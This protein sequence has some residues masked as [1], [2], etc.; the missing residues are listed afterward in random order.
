MFYAYSLVVIGGIIGI[1]AIAFFVF[2]CINKNKKVERM[3]NFILF[4]PKYGIYC[5]NSI[6]FQPLSYHIIQKQVNTIQKHEFNQRDHKRVLFHHLQT[7][8]LY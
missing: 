5:L 7:K 3:S 1:I 2:Y 4:S 8:Q 6:Y